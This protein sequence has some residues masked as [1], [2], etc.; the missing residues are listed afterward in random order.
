MIVDQHFLARN[1]QQRLLG[2]LAAHPGMVGLG[3]DEGAAVVVQGRS[4]RVVGNSD[5]VACLP[6]SSGSGPKVETLK[7][8]ARADLFALGL[9]A[10]KPRRGAGTLRHAVIDA[11]GD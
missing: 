1:R 11:T 5:V 8:G 7:P 9:A 2:A 3:I 4:M 10:S 6:P